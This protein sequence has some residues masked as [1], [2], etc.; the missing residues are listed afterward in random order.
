MEAILGW[1]TGNLTSLGIGVALPFVFMFSKKYIVKVIGKFGSAKIKTTIE[2]LDEI[3]DPI[4]KKIYKDWVLS[5]VKLIEFEIPDKG[6]GAVKFKKASQKICSFLPFLKG[7]E[8][9]IRDIIESAV[10]AMDQEAKG[11]IDILK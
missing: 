5:T 7:Q 11:A 3:D 4:K 6:M 1:I 8:K 9:R 2:N 10:E